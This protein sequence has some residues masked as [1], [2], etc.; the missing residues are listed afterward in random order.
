MALARG[1]AMARHRSALVLFV[2]E[3]Y[4][5]LTILGHFDA[6]SYLVVHYYIAIKKR[7]TSRVM[8]ILLN[9]SNVEER[10]NP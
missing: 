9:T 8:I 6:V 3:F 10:Q 4:G 7:Y 2:L 5:P 1:Y